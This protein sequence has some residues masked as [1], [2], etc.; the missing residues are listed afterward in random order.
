MPANITEYVGKEGVESSPVTY[1]RMTQPRPG[2][3]IRWADGSLGRI[4]EVGAGHCRPDE[5]HVCNSLGR[6]FL[7]R[8]YVSV[9]GG[10]FTILKRSELMATM[11][12]ELAGFWNWG[13]NS[14]GA[15]R[16][17]EYWLAR[18]VFQVHCPPP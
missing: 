8:G 7:G 17:V 14:A 16:G 11:R 5:V 6:A 13:D 1:N 15:D 12:C 10:P 18:P 2:D 3:L 4:C 9:G